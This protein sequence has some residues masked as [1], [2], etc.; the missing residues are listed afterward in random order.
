VLLEPPFEERKRVRF[1]YDYLTMTRPVLH[2]A[3]IVYE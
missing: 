3:C 1:R 2:G